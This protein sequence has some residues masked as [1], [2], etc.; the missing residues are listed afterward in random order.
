MGPVST[1]VQKPVANVKVSVERAESGSVAPLHD[2][3]LKTK[4]PA[5][6]GPFARGLSPSLLQPA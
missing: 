2:G 6:A 4:G 5:C 1:L 3:D